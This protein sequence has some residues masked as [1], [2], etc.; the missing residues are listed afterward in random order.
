MLR[1]TIGPFGVKD[2][3]TMVNLVSGVVAVHYVLGNAPRSAGY[4]VIVGF[5]LG[6]LVDGT[7]ARRTGTANRF[8]AEFDA[9]TD[10][11]VHVFVPALVFLWVYQRG[12]HGTLGLLGVAALVTGASV[13]H[14]RFAAVKFDFPLCWCGLPRTISGFL[15]LALPLT[16][17]FTRSGGDARY[18]VGLV[19]VVALSALNLVPV[20]YM[21]HRGQ[22]GMQTWVKVMLA[23]FFLGLPVLFVVSREHTFDLFFVGL[24][25][26]AFGGWFPVHPDERRQFYVEYRRW[27]AE[28]A[29]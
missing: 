2:L 28:L 7:V 27:A 3:F 1:R 11:F 20:P 13:R 9:I 15:A 12:G 22:R 8:G 19:V 23:I 14:A 25:C 21:T 5:L 17:P 4:A 29:R 26:F 6:D 10:H 18:A 24:G 16:T